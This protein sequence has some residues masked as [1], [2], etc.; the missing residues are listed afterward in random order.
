M[1][2]VNIRD[3]AREANVSSATVSRVINDSGYVSYETRKT[4]LD[5]IKTLDYR[6]NEIARNL[7]LRKTNI[8]GLILPDI[9]NYFFSLIARAVEDQ[10][11]S[12]NY[13]VMLCNTDGNISTEFNYLQTLI[14]NQ[15]SGIIIAG[16]VRRETDYKRFKQLFSSQK[17][18]AVLIDRKVEAEKIDNVRINN[19][20]GAKLA[21]KHLLDLGHIDIVLF[22][23]PA[24]INVS[25]ERELGYR[26][27]LK[28]AN[29]E[30][31]DENILYG[32]FKYESGL[33]MAST[34]LEKENMPS[35]IFAANDLIAIGAITQLKKIGLRVPGDVAVVGFD[36]IWLSSII[37]PPLTTVVQPAYNM[38]IFATKH[39]ID[40]I[41]NPALEMIDKVYDPYLEIRQSCGAKRSVKCEA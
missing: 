25:I 37:D 11:H 8:I 9:T 1:G 20:L 18:P 12:S 34:L 36:D 13:Q 32:D 24:H 28:E 17:V 16:S 19:F 22:N 23:G 15:V 40:K 27:A 7:S 21:T 6:P 39:L 33:H 10:A 30:I 41:N 35:S 3:V 38:G 5:V 29:I 2:P 26:S 4:V 14:K 31:N